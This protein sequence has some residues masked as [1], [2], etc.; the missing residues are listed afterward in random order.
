MP[1][2]S[3]F[4][5]RQ[6]RH[7]RI[8]KRISGT[9]ARPRLA[10]FVSNR[11]FCAQIIDDEKHHTLVAHSTLEMKQKLSLNKKTAT[12][13]GEAI[14]KKALAKKITE[15]VFDRGGYLFHGRIAAFA[16]AARNGGLKF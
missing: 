15:V 9:A 14:A 12:L 13:V 8:R 1:I 3:R 2:S 16:T 7:A 11:H 4:N 10:V 6:L 5:A